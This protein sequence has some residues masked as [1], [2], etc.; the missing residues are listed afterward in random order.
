MKYT[1]QIN[2][3]VG[4]KAFIHHE[5][6]FDLSSEREAATILVATRQALPPGFGAGMMDERLRNVRIDA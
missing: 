5:Q 1:L 3:F 6:V 4:N 2:R